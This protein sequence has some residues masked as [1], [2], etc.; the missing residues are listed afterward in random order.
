[1]KRRPM[2]KA[3]TQYA[4]ADGRVFPTDQQAERHSNEVLLCRLEEFV[5]HAF[6]DNGHRPSVIRAVEKMADERALTTA[7]LRE[8]LEVLT[9]GD[10]TE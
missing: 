4:A 3:V 9:F 10:E 8:I 7:L 5:K 1:M 6:P 2:I